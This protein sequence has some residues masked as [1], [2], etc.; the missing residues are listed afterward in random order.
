MKIPYSEVKIHMIELTLEGLG[1]HDAEE[2]L[3]AD[4]PEFHRAEFYTL[5]DVNLSE[6]PVAEAPSPIL[7]ERYVQWYQE[8]SPFPAI[9]LSVLN[10]EVMD[11]R[12]RVAA[13]RSL[14]LKSILCY[15]P[16]K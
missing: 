4:L 7:V 9:V 6:I 14:N 12:H 10:N 5:Q 3:D 2:D 1:D 13:A 11:G 16:I 8:G 15:V